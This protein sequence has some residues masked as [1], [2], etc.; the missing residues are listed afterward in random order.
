MAQCEAERHN[1]KGFLTTGLD[2]NDGDSRYLLSSSNDAWHSSF[3]SNPFIFFI[4]SKNETILSTNLDMN[5][6]RAAK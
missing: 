2:S 4:A 1:I 6:L 5:E 3:H